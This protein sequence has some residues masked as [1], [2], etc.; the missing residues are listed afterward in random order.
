MA[1]GIT[2]FA[3][4]A[5]MLLVV[6]GLDTSDPNVVETLYL[7]YAGVH[8][9]LVLVLFDLY[10]RIRMKN[11]TTTFTYTE[12]QP[13]MFGA[14]GESKTE[15][16]TVLDYDLSK[17]YELVGKRI[18]MGVIIFGFVHYKW[19][20]VPPL[21]YQ[22][23]HNPMQLWESQLFQIYTMGQRASGDYSRPWQEVNPMLRMLQ[24]KT[25][26]FD[27]KAAKRSAKAAAKAT[28]TNKK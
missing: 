27:K 9:V 21:I 23:L 25:E 19:G 4:V 6:K 14:G 28:A 11:D 22:C 3:L 26:V 15:V 1:N 10:R 17:F 20:V 8:T 12:T 18:G 24:N 13:Q 5:I 7:L 16:T 2:S